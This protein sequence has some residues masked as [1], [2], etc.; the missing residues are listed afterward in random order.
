MT[1]CLQGLE[2][3]PGTLQTAL[4]VTSVLYSVLAAV[5]A[6]LTAKPDQITAVLPSLV[7]SRHAG[8][9]GILGAS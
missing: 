9:I 6:S 8:V 1:P 4:R 7:V 5:S 2:Q 3:L